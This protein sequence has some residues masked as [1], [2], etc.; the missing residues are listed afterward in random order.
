MDCFGDYG[1]CDKGIEEC[2]WFE[3]CQEEYFNEEEEED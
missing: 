2:E 3:E 1:S